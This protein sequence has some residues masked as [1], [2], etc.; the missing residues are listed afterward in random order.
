[1]GRDLKAGLRA[2]KA[3]EAKYPP[4][5]DLLPIIQAKLSLLPKH[6]DPGEGKEYAEAVV[7]KAVKQNDR[8][9][10]ELAYSIL[11]NEKENKD[12]LA[13]AVRAAEVRVRIDGGRDARSL[14]NLSD[15]YLVSGDK[16]KAKEHARK[17]IDAAAG[18]SSTFQQDIEKEARKLGAEK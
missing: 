3:L 4:V 16:A 11:R 10:L 8:V 7:A 5:A 18:E 9:V 12:L 2:V 17:A 14:L 13:L 15:A 1:A 6:G